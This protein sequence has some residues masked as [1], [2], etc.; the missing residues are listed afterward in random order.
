M[1]SI[2]EVIVTSVI[3]VIAAVG[4]FMT[5]SSIRPKGIAAQK[6]LRAAYLGK[7]IVENILG[8]LDARSWDNASGELYP[9]TPKSYPVVDGTTTYT[10]TWQ[11][12]NVQGMDLRQ[13][14]LNVTY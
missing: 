7:Q 2:L 9:G 12:S 10:V 14:D 4:I 5:I 6:K 8:S 13:V 11:V 1:A 3:F